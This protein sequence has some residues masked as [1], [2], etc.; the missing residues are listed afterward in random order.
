MVVDVPE[1]GREQLQA[2]PLSPRPPHA[3]EPG[4]ARQAHHIYFHYIF[5]VLSIFIRI[6]S[7]VRNTGFET[8]GLHSAGINI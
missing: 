6:P 1:P 3:T 5:V 8:G 7:D 2:V 4:A